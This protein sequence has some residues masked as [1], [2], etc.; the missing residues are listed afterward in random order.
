MCNVYCRRNVIVCFEVYLKSIERRFCQEVLKY[1][2]RREIKQ[3]YNKRG[4]TSYTR[5]I[6]E[7]RGQDILHRERERAAH[8]KGMQVHR[9]FTYIQST[10]MNVQTSTLKKVGI[11]LQ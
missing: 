1:R 9:I 3:V 8:T 5:S 10:S 7:R 11:K 6:I 2:Q 4:Q